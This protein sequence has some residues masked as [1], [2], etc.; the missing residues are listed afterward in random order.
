MTPQHQGGQIVLSDRLLAHLSPV[1]GLTVCSCSCDRA[2]VPRC[3]QAGL[4]ASP[5]RFSTVVVT[6]S[7]SLLSGYKSWPMPGTLG[8]EF[9]RLFRALCANEFAPTI[10]RIILFIPWIPV[11]LLFLG[12]SACP[13]LAKLSLCCSPRLSFCLARVRRSRFDSQGSGQYGHTQPPPAERVVRL[14][15]QR[16][17]FD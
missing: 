11:Q 4:A 12:S 13:H 15:V 1:S 7:G 8:G 6:L 16:G 10:N 5:L 17:P 14:R 2:L 9:I 3:F